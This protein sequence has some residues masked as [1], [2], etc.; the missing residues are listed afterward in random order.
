MKADYRVSNESYGSAAKFPIAPWTDLLRTAIKD[1]AE[2]LDFV[3]LSHSELDEAPIVHPTFPLLVPR[4][5][6]ARMR[7]RDPHDPLL[8][9]VLPLARERDA[10]SGFVRD[11][12][13]EFERSQS[14]VIRK[15]AG[16]AL[17]VTTAACP[18]HCRYCFR[19]HFPYADQS[20]SRASWADAIAAL[21]RARDIS[22]VILSGGDPLTLANS[23]LK[24]LIDKLERLDHL[25]TLRIHTRFPIVLPERIDA[26]L[27][28][29]LA[30]SRLRT[31]VV[32][33]CNHAQE[34]DASVERGLA[35]LQANGVVLLNQSVLLRGVNDDA[36]T[37]RA[38]SERL[39][40]AHVLPY[41][42]HALD[43]VA[44]SAHF[45]V[46]ER[47]ALALV[48]EIRSTLPGYL[49]PRLVRELPGGISKTMLT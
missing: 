9:Q 15:Y 29:S 19:R 31:V 18:I 3:E 7:K 17:L 34:I 4:G 24:S 32:V 27:L 26:E 33:H 48:E 10:V 21:E 23:R 14:G 43:P 42:L 20:A 12:L 8:R 6:A 11:P 38:L 30:A 5:F 28:S 36:A 22:E 40:D 49:V 13:A 41:Y 16:R 39:L 37:L 2:L 45:D 47:E 46:P 25:R 44:G 35:A 1:L